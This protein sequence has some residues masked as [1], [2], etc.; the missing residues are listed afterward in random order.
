MV[1]KSTMKK[2]ATPQ[3][4]AAACVAGLACLLA[5]QAA[6]AQEILMSGPLAGAPAVRK[7]R[8]YREGRFEFT[9]SMSFSILEQYNKSMLLGATL[10][11]NLTD[12]LAFGVWGGFGAIQMSTSLTDNIE[13]F[14]KARSCPNPGDAAPPQDVN[15]RDLTPLD[16]RLT[17]VNLPYNGNLKKQLGQIS[18]VGAP[19]LTVIPFRGKISMFSSFYLDTELRFF[20]GL[21]FVGLSERANCSL[22]ECTINH[23]RTSRTAIT[24]TFGLGLTFFTHQ[25]GGVTLD[26]RALPL[27]RNI[28]GF[29]T[30]GTGLNDAFPDLRIND[31]DRAFKFNQLIAVGYS[32]FLP[33]NYRV[34]E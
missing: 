21:A 27:S 20:G 4:L 10:N 15:G 30:A 16:C 18:W 23:G 8:L 17:A 3:R 13:K 29:D 22:K 32:I 12:W 11:Y 19:Q 6:Q 14:H 9:P 31:K 26:W 24:G 34:S 1:T 2:S 7:L 25:W 28:G 33:F 5:S